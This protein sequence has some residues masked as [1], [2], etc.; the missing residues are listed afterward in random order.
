MRLLVELALVL[1]G[2]AAAAQ[3]IRMQSPQRMQLPLGEIEKVAR[4]TLPAFG[5]LVTDRNCK[6]MGFDSPRQAKEVRLGIPLRI[7]MV[8]LASLKKYRPGD[9]P[10]ALVRPLDQVLYPVLVGDQTRSSMV[11]S[12]ID[13]VWQPTE[14]GAASVIK[15][16]DQLRKRSSDSTKL[17]LESYFV[18]RIPALNLEFLGYRIDNTM[19]L[20]PLIDEPAYGFARGRPLPAARV[21][22][23]LL[24]DAERHDGL[25]W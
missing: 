25:P 16:L 19:M 17:S 8:E 21:F 4:G 9:E 13:E 3:P 2:T 14:I 5:E 18:V 7:F 24:P 20:T 12:R 11:I 1:I 15:V 23:A 10:D 6:A 22:E